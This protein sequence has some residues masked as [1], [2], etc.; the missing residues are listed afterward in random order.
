MD[1]M[2]ANALMR[3]GLGHRPN[4]G[5][6]A[7]PAAWLLG[8]LQGPDLALGTGPTTS[9]GLVALRADRQNKPPP[10]ESQARAVFRAGVAAQLDNAIATTT[11]FRERLV[12]FWTNHF[13]VSVRRASAR[14]CC[15]AS[16]QKRSGRM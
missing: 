12:W 9:E 3:F 13:T 16:C 8:Q 11:P 6:P 4:E 10:G 14:P 7:D 2:T 5:L 1:L 15:L